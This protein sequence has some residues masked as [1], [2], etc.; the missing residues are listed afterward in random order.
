[1]PAI[2]YGPH[3]VTYKVIGNGAQ[4]ILAFHGALL[5]KDA[6]DVLSELGDDFTIIALDLPYHGETN[7]KHEIVTPHDIKVIIYDLLTKFHLEKIHLIGYSIGAK[8]LNWMVQH[9]AEKI[10]SVIYLAP[11]GIKEDKI[12]QLATN[13]FIGKSVFKRVTHS[14]QLLL[15]LINIINGIGL[16]PNAKYKYLKK[17]VSNTTMT[18][19]IYH[20]WTSFAPLKSNIDLVISKINNFKI[21]TLLIYGT[22]D[23]IINPEKLEPLI[24][25][26]QHLKLISLPKAHHILTAELVS[27]LKIFYEETQ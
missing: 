10:L 13:N 1:M 17:I 2:S 5:D 21:P 11:D 20:V 23:T 6:F 27:T 19:Q 4:Y 18:R 7:W 3:T 16:L 26:V 15:C 25:G 8:W 22:H 24:R 9:Y 12:Y 14:N